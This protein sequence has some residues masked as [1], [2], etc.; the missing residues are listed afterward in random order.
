MTLSILFGYV[1]L[2]F[3]FFTAN[4]VGVKGFRIVILRVKL[5]SEK[6]TVAHYDP[7]KLQIYFLP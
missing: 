3:C 5:S 1:M 7:P 2:C 4:L 6:I